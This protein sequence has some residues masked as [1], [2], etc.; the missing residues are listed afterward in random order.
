MKNLDGS[1]KGGNKAG[2][3][4]VKKN[5]DYTR[6]MIACSGPTKKLANDPSE[7]SGVVREGASQ[8]SRGIHRHA[9]HLPANGGAEGTEGAVG[10]GGGGGVGVAPCSRGGATPRPQKNRG[11]VNP[12][13]GGGGGLFESLNL[14]E[15]IMG[16]LVCVCGPRVSA[17]EPHGLDPELTP[18]RK[19]LKADGWKTEI[20]HTSH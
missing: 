5:V 8:G 9:H 17:A 13:G 12:G 19:C 1:T 14:F 18:P 7:T 3:S 20:I 11:T 6:G 15:N 16:T 4:W 2:T 10:R